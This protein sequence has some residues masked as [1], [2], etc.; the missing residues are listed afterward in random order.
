MNIDWYWWIIIAIAIFGFGFWAGI[1][2]LYAVWLKPSLAR[3]ILD[4]GNETY[5][6]S[7][8]IKRNTRV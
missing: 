3:G 7:R 5:R 4:F 6:M 2:T 8:I 1:A